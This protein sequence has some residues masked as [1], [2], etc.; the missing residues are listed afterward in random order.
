[1]RLAIVTC[2]FNPIG[3]H[4]M[5]RNFLRFCRQ[6]QAQ[7]L[8]LFIAELAFGDEEWVSCAGEDTLLLRTSS[9]HVFW[10]KENLLNLVERIVP[11]EFSGLAWVDADVWFERDDWF[12]A[13]ERALE[14]YAVVQMGDSV[15]RTADDGKA[16]VPQ[17]T[18]ASIG[19]LEH[20]MNHP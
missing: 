5:R 12:L 2:H 18:A 4:E 10:Y 14:T 19:R 20:G 6:I 16:R 13:T 8:P 11:S 1:M 17:A 3:F 9:K 15:I 7:Q